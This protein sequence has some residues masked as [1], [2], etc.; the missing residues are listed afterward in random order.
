LKENIKFNMKSNNPL[1]NLGF[2]ESHPSNHYKFC[3]RCGSPGMFNNEDFSFK[4]PVCGFHYFLNS[5]AAVTALIFNEKDELLVV[6]RGIE[7]A[8][9]MI[10]FPGGFVVPGE[11]VETALYR[12]IKEELNLVPSSIVFYGSFPNQY[13]FS[14]CTVNTVD[15]VFKCTVES[16]D[17]LQSLDDVSDFEFVKPEE[18]DINA[19]AFQSAKNILTQLINEQNNYQ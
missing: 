6:K 19:V 17:D 18:I 9:G 16:F 11:S 8:I 14:G 1:G 10:D 13:L 12:E 3:P 15:M 5:A 4:C 7:P 2:L